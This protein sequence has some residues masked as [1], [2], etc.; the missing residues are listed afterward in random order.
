MFFTFFSANLPKSLALIYSLRTQLQ[1]M[2]GVESK[3]CT[4]WGPKGELRH[5]LVQMTMRTEAWEESDVEKKGE[6]G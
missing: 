6:R 1:E 2:P 5:L 3:I 4:C